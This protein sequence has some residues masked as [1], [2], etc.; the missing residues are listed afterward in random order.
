MLLAPAAAPAQNQDPR[1]QW[2]EEWRDKI[3]MDWIPGE[4]REG[5]LSDMLR[6]EYEVNGTQLKFTDQ[7]ETFRTWLS[8]APRPG[9]R[10]L[11]AIRHQEPE[12]HPRLV[13]AFEGVNSRELWREKAQAI[14]HRLR[15]AF[16]NDAHPPGLSDA[17]VHFLHDEQ[18]RTGYAIVDGLYLSGLPTAR[19]LGRW[20]YDGVLRENAATV[21]EYSD[22]VQPLFCRGGGRMPL[23]HSA[24]VSLC[25][26]LRF[27][28]ARDIARASGLPGFDSTR[29]QA[30]VP[31][32]RT[33][34][35]LDCTHQ[36]QQFWH[37]AFRTYANRLLNERR[38]APGTIEAFNDARDHYYARLRSTQRTRIALQD[39]GDFWRSNIDTQFHQKLRR[40][41]EADDGAYIF[42]EA[43]TMLDAI[44]AQNPT[45]KTLY[46][47][48]IDPRGSICIT[49]AK[50][51]ATFFSQHRLYHDIPYPDDNSIERVL[52]E[53]I[54]GA[55]GTAK[56][57][58]PVSFDFFI[59]YTLFGIRFESGTSFFPLR[60]EENRL[61]ALPG[62]IN[63]FRGF[64]A[65]A[66][67]RSPDRREELRREFLNPHHLVAP[68]LDSNLRF[69]LLHLSYMIG[70]D[71]QDIGVYFNAAS[72]LNTATGQFIAWI[73]NMAFDT[74]QKKPRY[75][76][77]QSGP[78]AGKSMTFNAIG[79]KL[80]DPMHFTTYTD[81][82]R[83]MDQFNGHAGLNV[84]TLLEEADLNDMKGKGLRKLQ[85]IISCSDRYERKLF[86][87]GGMVTDFRF[88]AVVTNVR[89]PVSLPPGQRRAVL[90]RFLARMAVLMENHAFRDQ[91]HSRLAAVLA[92][93]KMWEE[94][95]YLLY[96]VYDT[97]QARALW[98][99]AAHTARTFNH[100]TCQIQMESLSSDPDTSVLGWLYKHLVNHDD[101]LD[102]EGL[103][104]YVLHPDYEMP[105]PGQPDK[106]CGQWVDLKTCLGQVEGYGRMAPGG[107]TGRWRDLPPAQPEETYAQRCAIR[108]ERTKMWWCRAPMSVF[109][110]S[111]KKATLPHPLLAMAD[112]R[113][114]TKE[115]FQSL[116]P[117][118][119]QGDGREVFMYET[120]EK[121]NGRIT[122][123]IWCLAPLPALERMFKAAMPNT[124]DMD[125][126][127]FRKEREDK[128]IRPKASAAPKQPGIFIRRG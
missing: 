17:V 9:F 32:A 97:P 59:W 91:Y 46:I 118:F 110:E 120:T 89:R 79:K 125:W 109:Y 18:P 93:D 19:A 55:K 126:D 42:E 27:E 107:F 15:S 92:D 77:L 112:F 85:E 26:T 124:G 16:T 68:I 102:G 44:F 25:A 23:L 121:K 94:F 7:G 40:A 57:P 24:G 10:C 123:E 53:V 20:V 76:I 86:K 11:E 62:Y 71:P 39:T 51:A 90:A 47:K 117:E 67:L 54:P 33:I 128:R 49:T 50:N 6:A 116:N 115:I 105:F 45:D 83:L 108:R 95:A 106:D 31:V 1:R 99:K 28:D 114:S 3:L 8:L 52:R 113:E 66:L 82:D 56:K 127:A 103:I 69:F 43:R 80:L 100:D 70:E 111:Y 22:T 98:E 14:C 60:F 73:A 37:E 36:R 84:F 34:T 96:S 75:Y 4:A 74:R 35:I 78:G 87:E 104:R 5:T 13:V 58:G 21:A 122:E 65:H 48:S 30:H 101:L 63:E 88:F 38:A 72:S 2:P 81:V 41:I 12:W 29:C 119:F 64:R 61:T